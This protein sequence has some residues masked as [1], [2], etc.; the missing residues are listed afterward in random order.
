MLHVAAQGNSAAS[1]Y[2]FK[3]LGL[4]INSTDKRG[5]TPLHWA[6]YQ[7]FEI[8]LSFILSWSPKLDQKNA[9]INGEGGETPVHFALKF[10]DNSKS[11]RILRFLLSKGASRDVRNARGML[12]IDYCQDIQSTVLR[13]EAM[14]MLAKPGFLFRLTG[15]QPLGPIK[16]K[17]S[18]LIIF[19]SLFF[20]NLLLEVLFIFPHVKIKWIGVNMGLTISCLLFLT[21]VC[22]KN[23]GYLKRSDNFMAMVLAIE[24][25]QLCPDCDCV[26]TS[27]SRH[28]AIC[29]RCVERF[30]H[31]CPWVNNCI[32]IHNHNYFF[33]FL[34]TMLATLLMLFY[35][36]ARLLVKDFE[37]KGPVDDQKFGD[38]I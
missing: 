17:Q 7:N 21:V 38:W 37:L 22:T 24:N 20:V 32:G 10:V 29:N 4:D 28:C 13:E 30:D 33:G 34:T 25:S 1:L 14:R 18:T 26:R 23:P 35:Q 15:T 12:P 9:V 5:N 19:M 6:V 27:R 16:N 2:F 8:A 31:H 11:N 36:S 3:K